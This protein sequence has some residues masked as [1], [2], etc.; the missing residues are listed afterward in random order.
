MMSRTTCSRAPTSSAARASRRPCRRCSGRGR[1]R[2][3]R[4]WS[5][6]VGQRQH[7]LAVGDGHERQLLAVEELLDH[8]ARAGVA[9]RAVGAS[10]ARRRPWPRRPSADDDALAGGQPVGLH[11]HG[12]A[13]LVD[14]ASRLRRRR[15]SAPNARRRHAR[16]AHQLLG[17]DLASPRAAPPRATGPKTAQPAPRER[18]RQPERRAAASGPTTTRS[19]ACSRA[20]ARRAPQRRRPRPATQRARR[21]RCRGSRA[22]TTPPRRAGSR[23]SFQASACSRPPLPTTRTRIASLQCRKWRAPV[24]TIAMPCSSAA[25]DHLGVA[26]RAAG[27]DDGRRARRRRLVDAVAER[28]ERVGAEHRAR[29]RMPRAPPRARDAHRVDARHLAGADARVCGRSREARWRST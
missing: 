27:L 5:C 9:E 26:H 14:E 24:N 1:R 2:R 11:D 20:T 19:I 23:A 17:E 18:V 29:E 22:R 25:R 4:L 6:D 3:P 12:R 15:R 21:P 16:R 28:E 7:G 10:S 13:E 8:D